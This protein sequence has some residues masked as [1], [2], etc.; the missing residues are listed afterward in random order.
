MELCIHSSF[1]LTIDSPIQLSCS[2]NY[3]IGNALLRKCFR[4]EVNK[5]HGWQKKKKKKHFN[6][7][8]GNEFE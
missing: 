7:N 5:N 4:A 1:T 3:K 8:N 2:Q 6:S